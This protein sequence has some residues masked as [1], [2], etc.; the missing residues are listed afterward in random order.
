MA[1]KSFS[2][3]N[4]I[5]IIFGILI[6]FGLYLTSLYNYL[7]FHG[8][9]ETF[10]ITVACVI[11]VLAW[12]SQKF[13]DNN[14]L[15][16]IG[17][18]YL[19]IA[20]LE[21]LHTLSYPGMEIF[22]GYD[23]DLPTQ[24]WIAARYMESLS[25]LIAP[26]LFGR[27][28]RL[29]LLFIIYAF[30]TSLIFFSIFLWNNFPVCFVEG[31]G[32]TP[33][34]KIS[35]YIICLIFLGAIAFLYQKR[36]EFEV[37]VY[38]LLIVSIVLSIAAE[39]SF[40][41]YIHAYDRSN[42]VG[43][44]FTV[45]SF[46]FIYK[47]I[48]ETGLIRPYDLLFRNLKQS[49][50]KFKTVFRTTPNAITITS[51]EDGVYTDINNGF[52][53]MLGYSQEDVIG[54]SALALNIWNDP[55]QRK[56]LL[57]GLKKHGSVE[58]MEADF[59]GKKGQIRTGL[60]SAR[61]LSIDNNKIILA[62]TQD[63]TEKKQAQEALK[64][65]EK[66]LRSI[67]RA[68]PTGIGVVRDRFIHQVNDRFCEITGYSKNELIGQSSRI[69]YQT[70]E[71]YEYVGKEKYRQ[72]SAR[73]TGTVETKFKCKD[74]EII[75]VLLSSTPI[76]LNDLSKGVTFTALDITYLK[77]KESELLESEEKYRTMME[78]MEEP[79]TICTGDYKINYMNPAM[80]RRTGRDA[81]GENCFKALHDLEEKCPWCMADQTQQG[82]SFKT[83][84]ISPKDNRSYH[85]SH[86]PIVHKN[87]TI[88]KMTI[89]RD[90]TDFKELE[91]RLRQAQKMESIGTLAGGIAHDFNNILFPILGHTEML[92]EDIAKDSPFSISP[93]EIYKGAL[94]AKDLVRQILTFSRQDDNELTLMK[95]QPVIKEALKLIRSS[96]PATIDIKQNIQPECG[97][98][99]ADP[100]QIHQIIM[101]LT[102]NAYHAMEDTGGALEVSLKEVELGALDLIWPDMAPGLY[103]CLS[104]ADTGVG[105]DRILTDKIFDPFFT[106]KAKGKGTGMGLSVVHGIVISMNG[107]IQV[108]SEPGKGTKFH[109]Y[110]PV[111][112]SPSKEQA[113]KSKAKIQG[114]TEKILLIDD[115]EAILKMEKQMLERLGYH[116]ISCTSSIEALE[117]FSDNPDRFD[118]VITDMA[119]PNMPGDKLSVELT[120]IRPGIPVLLCTGF[121]E[122]MSQEK[123]SSLGIKGF[124]L[125]PIVMKDLAQ[126]IRE[127]LNN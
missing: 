40:T 84:I 6:L 80:I 110:F 108:F 98:I 39:L 23:A 60:M 70:D 73:G 11:F 115:E 38:R 74:G 95:I 68:A 69:V 49:E 25:L 89:F 96:I 76:D 37:V 77:T 27:R 20:V 114:G 35:E 105:M 81:T 50:E 102:T 119:M 59:I 86:A 109:V 47:A 7:L 41:S 15:F 1:T 12:N 99:K 13:M 18:A 72:I 65:N 53:K 19:F 28:I 127:V 21:L 66:E 100:T 62:V 42:L 30:A 125:K 67:F 83:D 48:I 92:L 107:A 123:A 46:Y 3:N 79:V 31:L 120:R 16:F 44:Y 33:F 63:I 122:T 75:D 124:L 51:V 58:S 118:I 111:E 43:H 9:A 22:K 29:S 5:R 116:V 2:A 45:I 64:K 52:T 126:K 34:K 117:A 17:I 94:R 8:I 112:K 93:N 61:L 57:S 97:V 91:S 24:L 106:T 55:E 26:L 14:Y 90:V 36:K 113:A 85:I 121:S 78:A 54:K 32:L 103:A 4:W 101:N 10:I 71:E 104:I 56:C 82:L 88:L 87:G